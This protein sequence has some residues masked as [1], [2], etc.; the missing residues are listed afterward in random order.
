[1]PLKAGIKRQLGHALSRDWL[2][3]LTEYVIAQQEPAVSLNGAENLTPSGQGWDEIVEHGR[4][5]LWKRTLDRIDSPDILLLEFGVWKG[6]SMR[7][8]VKLNTSDRSKFYGFDSFEALPE[9]WRGTSTARFDVSGG[10]PKI[11]D[12]HV[13]FIKGWFQDTLPPLL[14]QLEQES[15]GPAM[16]V[17]F[18]ADL[19]F[20]NALSAV[21]TG[22]PFLP[23][24]FH[25]RRIQ[26]PRN[27]GAVQLHPGDRRGRRVFYSVE[28]EGM[29]QVVSGVLRSR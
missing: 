19:L 22:S 16:V 12:P 24:S 18:D 10:V 3:K 29:P 5:N 27:A 26:R 4:R 6:D 17:H 15:D 14:D 28:W 21:R 11:D 20:F 8:F 7:E 1:M 2:E 9:T 13:T 23:V 25:L